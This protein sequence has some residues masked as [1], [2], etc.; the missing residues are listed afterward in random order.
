[1][2]L[3]EDVFRKEQFLPLSGVNIIS[4]DPAVWNNLKTTEATKAKTMPFQV[5]SEQHE[6]LLL[7]RIASDTHIDYSARV[8]RKFCSLPVK[9]L[10][11]YAVQA[12]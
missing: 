10:Y 9:R 4:S 6:V 12:S 11:M 3:I 1:M 8:K 2:L 7:A 5:V